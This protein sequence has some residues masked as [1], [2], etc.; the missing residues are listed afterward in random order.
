MKKYYKIQEIA[1]LYHIKSDSLR[2]YEKVGL[3]HPI[4]SAS[5]YRLYTLNDIYIL[6]IIRDC[7]HLGYDTRQIKDYLDHR[8]V[9]NTISFL[10]EEQK[11]VEEQI[12]DLQSKRLSIQ[13]RIQDLNKTKHMLLN[14]YHIQKFSNRY[15]RYLKEKIEQDETIDYLLTKLSES[16]EKDISILGNMESGSIIE[17]IK[18]DFVY[19]SVFI[20]TDEN[21]YDF[22]LEEGNYCTYTYKGKQKRTKDIF[23][24][25]LSWIFEQHYEVDG[26]FL[27]FLLVDIHETKNVEEY[28][29]SIHV[30]VK[31]IE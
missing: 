18:D 4:R 10:M 27:E 3:I 5:N 16:M 15:C 14:T 9:D 2:Y 24:N 20:L 19:T 13:T 29:T 31:L 7:L 21:K 8:S 11:M 23:L 6:N 1:K 12:Q 22:I 30:K 28:V 25:M 26:P 17:Y